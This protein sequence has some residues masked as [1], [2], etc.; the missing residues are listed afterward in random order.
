MASWRLYAEHCISQ[1]K[2]C[3]IKVDEIITQ[4]CVSKCGSHLY[5]HIACAI[6]FMDNAKHRDLV[7]GH[8]KA[9]IGIQYV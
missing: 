7:Y 2:P 3:Y 9:K 1:D 5:I 8:I 4:K 6:Y